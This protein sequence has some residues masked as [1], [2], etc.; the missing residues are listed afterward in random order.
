MSKFR[1]SVSEGPI[2]ESIVLMFRDLNRD[3]SVKYL[4]QHQGKILEDYHQNHIHSKDLAIELPTGTGKTL[5]GLLI[6]EYRRR[7]FIVFLCPTKQLCS[8]INQKAQLY[9]I[10]TSLLVGRQKN[11]DRGMFYEYQQGKAIAITTYSGLFNTNPRINDPEVIICDDAH[12]AD[13]YITDLWTLSISKE[14]HIS[15]Y[16]SI[17]SILEPVIPDS[18]KHRIKTGGS[19]HSDEYYV[20]MISTIASFDYYTHLSQRIGEVVAKDD[21]L[22]YSW[23]ILSS[24]FEACS[25]YISPKTLEIRPLIPPTKTHKPF[26]NAKQRVYMSATLGED[27]DIERVFGIKKIARLP[28]PE[29]WH[30]RSTGRRLILF[31]GLSAN[32]N[33]EEVA[34]QMLKKVNRALILVP[35]DPTIQEWEDKISQSHT[36][37]KSGEIEQNLDS[38]TKCPH[39]SALLLANRYDGIDLP[40]DNCRFMILNSEPSAS[41]LQELYLRTGLGASSQLNN[42]IRTRITQAMGRCTRDESDYSVVVVL[43]DKLTERC[44]TSKVTKGMHPEL[45]A[46]ISFG[47][48][49]S[50]DRTAEDFVELAEEFLTQTPG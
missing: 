47:L 3:S 2:P 6:A 15:L 46:E 19:N 26:S 35:N 25:I 42:R 29:E 40:G 11:Y 32:E 20:D 14:K 49:N 39:F 43:G 23:S 36:V 48:D 33:P 13:N 28:I 10:K 17:Y 44:C 34:V 12:S 7:A 31:P 21:D 5:V 4:W 9:G 1:T 24:H 8:Q 16:R 30:K 50:T 18:M 41:G 27:G 22:E 38:F 37:V 45:Q